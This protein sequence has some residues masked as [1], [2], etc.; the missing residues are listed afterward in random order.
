MHT[1]N[2]HIL[3][4]TQFSD[5]FFLTKGISESS[6]SYCHSTN[7]VAQTS[8]STAIENTLGQF[9]GDIFNFL[10]NIFWVDLIK[11]HCWFS[12]QIFLHLIRSPK[13]IV[14]LNLNINTHNY[15]LSLSIMFFRIGLF[16]LYSS[17]LLLRYLRTLICF[18]Y[19]LRLI[20]NV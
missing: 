10:R 8:I 16:L 15:S 5:L 3:F 14:C 17:S 9:F 6:L 7:D 18:L 4:Y 2:P 13:I 1:H 12:V 20:L 19:M 11:R